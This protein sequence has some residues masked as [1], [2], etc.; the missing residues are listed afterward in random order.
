MHI[1]VNLFCC[2]HVRKITIIAPSPWIRAAASTRSHMAQHTASPWHK[3]TSPAQSPDRTLPQTIK[4]KLGNTWRKDFVTVAVELVHSNCR[5][6]HTHTQNERD[7]IKFW[8]PDDHCSHAWCTT[9]KN[10]PLHL[11]AQ[12]YTTH[13]HTYTDVC[14]FTFT[15]ICIVPEGAV[16]RVVTRVRGPQRQSWGTTTGWY[17]WHVYNR[18]QQSCFVKDGRIN[19][20][21]CMGPKVS[22]PT[23]QLCHRNMKSSPRQCVKQTFQ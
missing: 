16:F 5:K 11:G 17:P 19:V 9:C 12:I 20:L 15:F 13:T 3:G 6:T 21:G 1:Y 8:L 23:T 4:Q 7:D 14:T 18:D 2:F 10:S 22:V